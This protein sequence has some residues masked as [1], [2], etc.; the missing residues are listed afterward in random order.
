MQYYSRTVRYGV[1]CAQ[2][3]EDDEVGEWDY[4]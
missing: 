3:V 4:I 2:V 1:H